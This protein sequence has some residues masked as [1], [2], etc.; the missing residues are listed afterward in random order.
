MGAHNGKFFD[1]KKTTAYFEDLQAA[2]DSY[3]MNALAHFTSINTFCDA[4][5]WKGIDA[6]AAKLLLS[7]KEYQ[8]LESII[9][10]QKEAEAL[11][12]DLLE[13]FRLDVDSAPDASIA[14]DDIE[15]IQRDFQGF[16]LD[17]EMLN[18]QVESEAT[19]LQSHFGQYASFSKPDSYPVQSAFEDFC[20][21]SVGFLHECMQKLVRFDSAANELVASK[22]LDKRIDELMLQMELI[23]ASP[24]YAKAYKSAKS[25]KERA[26]LKRK[27]LKR[28]LSKDVSAWTKDDAIN[29]A[30]W[31]YE[32]TEKK[33]NQTLEVFYNGLLITEKTSRSSKDKKDTYRCR[34]DTTKSGI[35]LYSL[36]SQ[37]RGNTESL[38]ALGDMSCGELVSSVDKGSVA[39]TYKIS[40][41][42]NGVGTQMNWEATA[43]DKVIAST[44]FMMF[45][46]A[47]LTSK[48]KYDRIKDLDGISGYRSH[49]K[50]I[51]DAEAI[52]EYESVCNNADFEKN[53]QYVKGQSRTTIFGL[54]ITDE[55]YEYI[56]DETS[57]AYR[58]HTS[59]AQYNDGLGKLSE[60]QRKT[61][62]YLYARD[63]KNG[64]KEADAY[65][66]LLTP[67]LR[68][69]VAMDEY[70]A[71][72]DSHLSQMGYKFGAGVEGVITGGANLFGA[73]DDA[74]GVAMLTKTQIA[75]Q[76]ISRNATGGWKYAYGASEGLGAA[77]PGFTLAFATGGVSA[78]ATAGTAGMYGLS[79]A[80][81]AQSMSEQSGY[82]QR[83]SFNYGVTEGVKSAAEIYALGGIAKG[84]GN[85]RLASGQALGAGAQALGFGAGTAGVTFVDQAFIEPNIGVAHLHDITRANVDYAE[86]GKQ[87]L[88]AGV[89]SAT[90][91]YG[92]SKVGELATRQ[93]SAPIDNE[94]S[95]DAWEAYL[96][97]KYGSNNVERIPQKDGLY[98]PE[99]FGPN[100]LIENPE[101][102]VKGGSYE[103]LDAILEKHNLTREEYLHLTRQ[104][105]HQL[106]PEYRNELI[107]IRM[108]LTADVTNEAG[109]VNHGT[110]VAKVVDKNTFSKF[111][112]EGKK[113][114]LN[115]C[116]ALERDVLCMGSD[117]EVVDSLGLKYRGTG[118]ID[119]SGNPRT[120]Y[121]IDGAIRPEQ[122]EIVVRISATT[123]SVELSDSLLQEYGSVHP[124]KVYEGY[125]INDVTSDNGTYLN[126]RWTRQSRAQVPELSEASGM[127]DEY[128]TTE[129]AVDANYSWNPDR[130]HGLT[131]N[132]GD[133]NSLGVPEF[134]TNNE[135]V[136][137]RNGKIYRVDGN[138]ITTIGTIDSNGYISFMEVLE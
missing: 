43:K 55:K 68:S 110:R 67:Y 18:R 116:V 8:L 19:Y 106:N 91:M 122:P 49:L 58:D 83:E 60:Q 40:V 93:K 128:I 56:N 102:I 126:Q 76:E 17:F 46:E 59:G 64:T 14:Y 13:M 137:I 69:E 27:E 118:F 111:Y 45:D 94:Y 11:Q 29:V 86:V 121:I 98:P 5:S 61:Y 108:E 84:L 66:E 44:Q 134:S 130:G 4:D 37:G 73:N 129:N 52:A 22:Q 96:K 87:S 24:D 34:L 21:G 72:K 97:E 63:L 100:D 135:L 124:D 132:Q 39:P 51:K 75:S 6:D 125:A 115:G 1:V 123:E 53:S 41:V 114:Y 42:H 3:Q 54:K 62:N 71:I 15:M 28:I 47:G 117:S 30:N 92:L 31:Y 99:P 36:L 82:S 131:L 109:V 77:V 79:A 74:D 38:G 113:A 12:G 105:Q 95:G 103:N 136:G 88:K 23:H 78:A 25:D 33:D 133:S 120:C 7:Q 85:V 101:V 2:F 138:G 20:D 119:E 32:A 112:E 65:L 70:N 48:E 81:S 26:K 127:K 9:Q 89:V 10:L 16:Q 107:Q 35:I 104:P 50:Q 80:G 57:R 90:T